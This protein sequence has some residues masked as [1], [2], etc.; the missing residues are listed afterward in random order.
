MNDHEMTEIIVTGKKK[1]ENV[2]VKMV[3]FNKTDVNKHQR[4]IRKLIWRK[5]M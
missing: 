3:N 5:E 1:R 2:N 4:K